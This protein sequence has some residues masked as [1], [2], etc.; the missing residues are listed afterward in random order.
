MNCSEAKDGDGLEEV[1]M[2]Y[3]IMNGII[4]GEPVHRI[5][6]ETRDAVRERA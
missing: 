1:K 2:V 5:M 3:E 4:G 6:T